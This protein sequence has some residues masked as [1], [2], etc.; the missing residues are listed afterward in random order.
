MSLS[1]KY[2]IPR[3]TI[4]KMVNDGVISCS[5]PGYEEIYYHY[6]RNL[7]TSKSKTEAINVTAAQRGVAESSVRYAISKME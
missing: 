4:T 1:D 3:E 6:K 2:N 5:W 7:A